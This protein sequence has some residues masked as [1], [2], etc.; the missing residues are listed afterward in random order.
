MRPAGPWQKPAH[1]SFVRVASAWVKFVLLDYLP[2]K[3]GCLLW[4]LPFVL[5]KRH[6]L[7]NDL[8]ARF[9]I[10]HLP[11]FASGTLV[12]PPVSER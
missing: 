5:R 10:Y 3:V 12:F 11:T 9:V 6:P 8:S 2:R 7:A 4:R 1:H